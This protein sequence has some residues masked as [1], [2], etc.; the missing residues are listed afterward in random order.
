MIEI[1]IPTY[2]RV[3]FLEK[4]LH[5]LIKQIS[6]NHLIDKISISISDNCSDDG[7]VQMV[8]NII[9]NTNIKI[10]LYEQ[11][12]NIGIVKNPVYLLEKATQ[13]YIMYLGDDDFIP[14]TYLQ[15]L[16]EKINEIDN[17]TCVIPG[18]SG[19]SSDG[20]VELVRIASFEEK[21]FE[22]S[23]STAKEIS[24]YGHQLSGVLLKR[25]N[26]FENYTSDDKLINIY[27]FIYFV[28]YNNLQG[29]SIYVP[30][31]QVLVSQDNA[32]EWKYDDS[33]LLTEIFKNYKIVFKNDYLKR[34]IMNIVF[35]KK[36]SWR[37]RIGDSLLNIFKA[38]KHLET[39]RDVEL[40]TK[41]YIPLIYITYYLRDALSKIKGYII[42]ES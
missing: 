13:P 16:I 20:V 37:L 8:E 14:D 3:T 18:F 27:P 6:E 42:N 23:F 12:E 34:N 10:I 40:L 2:N 25:E 39:S 29:R 7:T 5:I 11:S 31:Y 4:N 28:T 15:Y 22:P 24:H 1:L 17:L 35:M 41:I 38:I 19:L 32:K 36:Q 26:L 21:I 9:Q 33:G 30:K